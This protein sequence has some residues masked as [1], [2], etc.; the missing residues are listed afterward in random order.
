MIDRPPG[1]TVTVGDRPIEL[2]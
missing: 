1:A 2:R